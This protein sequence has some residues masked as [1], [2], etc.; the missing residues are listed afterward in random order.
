MDNI[1]PTNN[2]VTATSEASTRPKRRLASLIRARGRREVFSGYTGSK[3]RQ[4]AFFAMMLWELI[5]NGEAHYVDG[6][7]LIVT[8]LKEWIE[9]AKFVSNHLDGPATIDKTQVD[10]NFYKVYAG[11]D[12]D[13]V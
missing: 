10:V 11:I 6:K 12:P 7:A 9:L 2:I 4:D 8:E 5:T 13:K 1:I 3:I